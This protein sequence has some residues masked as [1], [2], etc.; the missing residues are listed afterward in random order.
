M[1]R[2]KRDFKAYSQCH[3]CSVVYCPLVTRALCSR[4]EFEAIAEGV[5]YEC[6]D[7]ESDYWSRLS[8]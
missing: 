2:K 7:F 3:E 8:A 6:P 1:R 5:R 4:M